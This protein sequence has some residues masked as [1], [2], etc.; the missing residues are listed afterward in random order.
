MAQRRIKGITITAELKQWHL[1]DENCNVTG[2]IQNSKDQKEYAEGE[3]FTLL[4]I[5]LI[6][7]PQGMEMDEHFLAKTQMGSY[8]L[9]MKRERR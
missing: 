3:R 1:D 8:F 2:F 7:Y 9:L 4:N 5:K 6:H